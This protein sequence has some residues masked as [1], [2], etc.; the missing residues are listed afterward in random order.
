MAGLAAGPG[1][2]DPASLGPAVRQHRGRFVEAMDNDLDTPSA[3]PA[4]LALADIALESDDA[5][6]RAEAGRTVR[7]LATRILG[8]RLAIVPVQ[9]E[10]GEAV[11]T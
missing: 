10:I 5:G 2:D 9:P 3:V 4:L 7:E 11:G 8:M 1:D 6:E